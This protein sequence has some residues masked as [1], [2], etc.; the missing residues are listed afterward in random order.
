MYGDPG[1]PSDGGGGGVQAQL[2]ERALTA[3]YVCVSVL[4]FIYRATEEL[5][6]FYLKE[7]YNF[8]RFKGIQYFSG[9]SNFS[10]QAGGGGGSNCLF[11]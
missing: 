9:G 8:Q 2:T 1:I 11:L 6:W 5:Q 4:N 10:E 3:F 7:S